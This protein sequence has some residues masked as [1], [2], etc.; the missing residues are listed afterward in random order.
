MVILLLGG[1]GF[2]LYVTLSSRHY[3]GSGGVSLETN[4]QTEVSLLT[5]TPTRI[6]PSV[7]VYVWPTKISQV[8]I[9]A[10][11]DD[12]KIIGY[13]D[14]PGWIDVYCQ[15]GGKFMTYDDEMIK[16]KQ[17]SSF[18]WSETRTSNGTLGWVSNVYIHGPAKLPDVPDCSS[19]QT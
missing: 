7:Q 6:E 16:S 11:T 3:H 18:W 4:T 15:R 9:F 13:I 5:M 10:E 8:P 17:N 19:N 1:S 12:S 2:F 14:S